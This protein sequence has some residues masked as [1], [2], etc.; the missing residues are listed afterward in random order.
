MAEADVIAAVTQAR[1]LL[2]AYESRR[3]QALGT[4]YEASTADLLSTL[5]TLTEAASSGSLSAAQRRQA[6]QARA[7]LASTLRDTRA[8]Y[9][10]GLQQDL[11]AVARREV[12]VTSATLRAEVGQVSAPPAADIAALLSR[13][14]GG[15][16]WFQRLD[17]DL[18]GVRDRVDAALLSATRQGAS[19]PNT[20]RLLEDALGQVAGGRARLTRLARTEMQRVANDAAQATYRAN[21]DVVV[22]VRYLATLD[23]RVCPVCQPLHREVFFMDDTG[24]HDGPPIPQ[25]PNCRCFYAPLPRTAAEAQG[26]A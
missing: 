19:I 13:P 26:A 7:A 20:V 21:R 16:T 17:R 8:A 4:A 12:T 5:R 9:R 1:T 3:T 24:G 10:A 15:S 23:S 6:E 11:F 2:V 14:V 25:H 22:G 18:L